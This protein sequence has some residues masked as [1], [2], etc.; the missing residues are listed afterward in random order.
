MLNVLRRLFGIGERRRYPRWSGGDVEIT[1]GDEVAEIVVDWSPGGFRI[2]AL[3]QPRPER[4]TYVSGRVRVGRV[5]GPYKA[6]VVSVYDDGSIGTRY[7][8]I[9]SAVFAALAKRPL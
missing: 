9:D 2:K 5:S 3:A 1:V 6:Y 4:G 8:E 7:D